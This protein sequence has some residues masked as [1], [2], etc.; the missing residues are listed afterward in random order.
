MDKS[1]EQWW[2]DWFN[3]IYMDVYAHR[4]DSSAENEVYT[5]FNQLSL[6]KNSTILDLCCGN[7]RHCRAITKE[8]YVK[9]IGIDYS[10]PLLQHAVS[11]SP[12]I[13]YIR[14]DMR[15]FPLDMKSI[16]AV[17]SF[18][19]S[20]GYFKTNIEN[21]TVLQE[22]SRVLKSSGVFMLDYLNPS[23]VRKNFEPMTE[24]KH[25]DITIQEI[26]SLSD[27]GER[28]EKEIHIKNWG[29][30]DHV[31]H[32]SVR[33]YEIEEMKEMLESSELIIEKVYGDFACNPFEAD[34]PRMI[35]FGKK[36]T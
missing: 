36:R 10:F 12:A 14:G 23:Q 4:D 13:S 25:G 1:K 24:K 16:D 17:V 31:Y 26:R 29:G 8:G 15:L 27:D 21:L 19:T 34:S 20:F 18:F 11:K 6:T 7:G 35:L 22:I 32:E 9:I 30:Q 3:D 2:R 5:T 28:I 33:L